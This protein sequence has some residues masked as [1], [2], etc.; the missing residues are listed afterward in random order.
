[1]RHGIKKAQLN[2]TISAR[3]ALEK[4]LIRSLVERGMIETTLTRAKAVQ[5][6]AERLVTWAKRGG[7]A[8][9]RRILGYLQKDALTDKVISLA[10]VFKLRSGGYTRVVKL[11]PRL[12]DQSEMARI[13]W[14][15]LPAEK[16]K[17][18]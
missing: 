15:E 1:M 11:G 18:L 14:V 8:N 16:E 6:R 17:K 4:G 12:S 2:M 9:Y 5:G 13:E 7:L 3:R 10:E